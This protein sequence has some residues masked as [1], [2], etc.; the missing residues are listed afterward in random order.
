M[1][2]ME[3]D[4]FGVNCCV[5]IRRA[6]N[7]EN[8]DSFPSPGCIDPAEFVLHYRL[9]ATQGHSDAEFELGM[10]LLKGTGTEVDESQAVELLRLSAAQ[11]Q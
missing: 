8:P 2:N 1:A 3:R 4:G 5:F 10:A 9:A 7:C 11:G 6:R